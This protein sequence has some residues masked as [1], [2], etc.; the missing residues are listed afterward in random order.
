MLIVNESLVVQN[1]SEPVILPPSSGNAEVYYSHLRSAARTYRQSLWEIAYF[2]WRLRAGNW[3]AELGFKDE[4]SCRE[5]VDIPRSTYYKYIRLGEAL[6]DLTM[7]EL[8]SLSVRNAEL[9][10]QV[11]DKII[12]EFP[13]VT[14][15]RTLSPADFAG[16]IAERNHQAGS[17]KEPSDYYRLKVPYSAKAA[18]EE[19][20]KAFQEKN[21]LASPAQALEFI[22]ADMFDRP[23]LLA[24]CQQASMTIKRVLVALR[25]IPDIEEE[26][27]SLELAAEEMDEAASHAISQHR[28]R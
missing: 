9:L 25:E 21:S 2:G 23:N 3:Y 12:G 8:Q 4:E 26:I 20:V 24:T 15:A 16:R 28:G 5:S 7:N 1:S 13:W 22:V 11:D 10:L 27:S 6:Q 19:S 17:D 14:E 18:I